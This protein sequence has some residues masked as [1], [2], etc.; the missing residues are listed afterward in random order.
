MHSTASL[1]PHAGHGT[2]GLPVQALFRFSSE[3]PE[4]EP[5][6][7]RGTV[8]GSVSGP[9]L[10]AAPPAKRA[11]SPPVSPT[12]ALSSPAAAA[13][14]DG[15]QG[16]AFAV[17]GTGAARTS[18]SGSP[19]PATGPGENA[20]ESRSVGVV[21]KNSDGVVSRRVGCSGEGSLSPRERG[22]A[23]KGAA[24]KLSVRAVEAVE[25]RDERTVLVC[26]VSE[27]ELPS[28][29]RCLSPMNSVADTAGFKAMCPC[30]VR[31]PPKV[32]PLALREIHR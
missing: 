29:V 21:G 18:G 20:A 8:R 13:A 22:A 32:E 14:A 31:Y 16:T 23:G 26:L 4:P 17:A 24:G 19:T 30:A 2:T 15:A 27:R 11:K 5:E 28:E 25:T 12:L 10:E 7:N 3:P 9:V 6:Q 1:E